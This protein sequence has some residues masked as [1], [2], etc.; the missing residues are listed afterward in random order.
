ML[1]YNNRSGGMDRDLLERY[2][3]PA[4]NFQVI[5]FVDATG[6]DVIPRKDRVWTTRGVAR[7]LI[8]ALA[9][10]DRPAPAYLE[11]LAGSR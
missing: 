3:E 11:D 7:R 10:V 2:D 5:R 1:V 8:E 4:W 6:K 9:A